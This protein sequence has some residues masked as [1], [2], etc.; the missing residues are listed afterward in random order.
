M[1]ARFFEAFLEISRIQGELNR[2]F[3]NL[4]EAQK[5]KARRLAG[6][7]VPE[8]DI[9]ESENY[10]TLKID[11]PGVKIEDIKLSV[12][13]NNLLISGIKRQMKIPSNKVKFHRLER[14]YGHF[15]RVVHLDVPID[16]NNIKALMENGLLT[17]IIKIFEKSAKE[18][19]IKIIKR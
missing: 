7:I 12:T 19:P 14:S 13:G 15:S 9:F 8:V 2:A 10:L 3:H 18:I 4:M 1:A 11:L 16:T 6:E 17:I 5:E